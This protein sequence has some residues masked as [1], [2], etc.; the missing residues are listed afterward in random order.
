MFQFLLEHVT[1][2][3]LNFITLDKRQLVAKVVALKHEN[4]LSVTKTA[5]TV[6]QSPTNRNL[7]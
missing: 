5:T 7:V 6:E 4:E 2:R 3:S 1:R